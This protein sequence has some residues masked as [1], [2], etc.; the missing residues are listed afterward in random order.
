M[1]SLQTGSKHGSNTR[2]EEAIRRSIEQSGFGTMPLIGAEMV[3]KDA[4]Q[5]GQQPYLPETQQQK[6]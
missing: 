3:A 4:K 5:E 1:M 2:K 6:F